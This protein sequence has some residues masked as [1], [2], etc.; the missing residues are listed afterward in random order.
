MYP[1]ND[2]GSIELFQRPIFR[3]GIQGSAW[4]ALFMVL[5]GFVNSLKPIRLA[6]TADVKQTLE[7]ISNSLFKRVLRLVLPAATTTIMSW[8]IVNLRLEDTA[9]ETESVWLTVTTPRRSSSVSA[10]L[11]DLTIGLKSTWVIAELNQYDGAQWV[12][13]WLL[14]GS[15]MVNTS[16]FLTASFRPAIRAGTLAALAIWSL[17]WS[18]AELDRM[19]FTC[20]LLVCR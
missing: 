16:L 4:V 8:L 17:D 5:L 13:I 18:F 2:D 14:F 19:S 1:C 15:V 6:R 10:A 20:K 9:R 7:T 12:L 11:W 3:L